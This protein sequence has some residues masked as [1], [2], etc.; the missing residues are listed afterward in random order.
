VRR[1]RLLKRLAVSN[2]NGG[3]DLLRVGV[4]RKKGDIEVSDFDALLEEARKA[5]PGSNDNEALVRFL[6]SDNY[7]SPKK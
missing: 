7:R 1:E 4:G 3:P 6:I 5:K 2:P